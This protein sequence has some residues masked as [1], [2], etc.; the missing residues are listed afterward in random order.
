MDHTPNHPSGTHLSATPRRRGA[1]VLIGGI[2]MALL[3]AALNPGTLQAA[4][5]EIGQLIELQSDP[6]SASPARLS[7]HVIAELAS[8][9]PQKQAEVL[10]QR[11]TN[12]YEGAIELID[13]HVEAWRGKINLTPQ[14]NGMLSVAVNSNDLRVR[15]AALEIYLAAYNLP[16]DEGSFV[17]LSSRI[18][19]DP[20]SR[21]WALWMLGALGNRGVRP[22]R[23]FDILREYAGDR[24]EETRHWAVEGMALLG[25]DETI[26]PLLDIFKSDPSMRIRE[27]AGCSLAQS[28]MLTRPQRMKAVPALLDMAAD[29]SVDTM[30]RGWVFQ[31]LR[32]I[33]GENHGTDAAAWRSWWS[34]R[35]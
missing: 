7:E 27:R 25:R 31:A 22:E 18:A 4:L 33:T 35:S 12:H 29:A 34:R 10:L 28:G 3:L 24:S 15:A 8:M 14:F 9:E 20:G 23:A 17:Q 26:Q 16:K 1:L 11:A 32:D 2:V 21:P 6:V 30:T 19:D 5:H 13:K